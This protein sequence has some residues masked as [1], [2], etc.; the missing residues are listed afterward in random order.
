MKV[1]VHSSRSMFSLGSWNTYYTELF[2]PNTILVVIGLIVWV[3]GNVIV[4]CVYQ[5]KIKKQRKRSFFIPI[6]ATVV[7]MCVSFSAV[8]HI[9]QLTH[10]VTFPNSWVLFNSSNCYSLNNDNDSDRSNQISLNW[11]DHEMSNYDFTITDFHYLYRNTFFY[12]IYSHIFRFWNCWSLQRQHHWV[13][14]QGN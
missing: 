3:I 11:P 9:L 8:Y 12:L 10:F 7:L 14:V 2:L 1:F 4:I 5:K 6:L 13:H